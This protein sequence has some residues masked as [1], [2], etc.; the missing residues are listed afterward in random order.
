[1]L[2]HRHHQ[3]GV[4]QRR[5]RACCRRC[6]GSPTHGWTFEASF[7][8]CLAVNVLIVI[9]GIERYRANL[10]ADER[11]RIQIVVFTGVP[12]VFAYALKTGIPL[13]FGLLGRPIELPWPIEAFLQAIVLLPAFG[14]PYAV[15][16]RHVFSPRTVLRRSLQYA[17]ARQ[18]ADGARGAAG[19]G[20]G[21]VAGP[22]ARP[23]AG[24][25]R[26]RTA[27]VLSLL[28]R[29][30]RRSALKYRDA[31]QRWLDQ[32][33]FR[34]EYDAREILRV[35]RGT[36]AVRSRPAR[37]GRDGRHP[38][39]F[40]APPGKHRRARVGF[41]DRHRTPPAPFEPVAALRVEAHAAARPTAA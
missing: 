29:D 28:P 40:G 35:A 23:V 22:A 34:D 41:A 18:H 8:L 14:L 7:A 30:A 20:A 25:D 31:A 21:G 27:A 26:Q 19:G 15:A 9:E 16:V 17:F 32:R 5:R 36:R 6:R 38:D 3:R 39:R 11:R 33:F 37:P 10:D 4:P 1:M 24:D 13:L 12:A 2:D